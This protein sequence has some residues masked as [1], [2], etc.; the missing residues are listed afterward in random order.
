[1]TLLNIYTCSEKLKNHNFLEMESRFKILVF[2]FLG[3][4]MSSSQMTMS[5]SSFI[6]AERRLLMR[7]GV[8][9]PLRKSDSNF[10]GL[11]TL[12]FDKSEARDLME[13]IESLR[14]SV[15]TPLSE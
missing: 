7:F 14:E 13:E 5:S 3:E 15:S 1:M 10:L 2:R 12:K 11:G 4:G 8:L 6:S 9:G